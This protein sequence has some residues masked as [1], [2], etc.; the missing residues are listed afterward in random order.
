MLKGGEIRLQELLVRLIANASLH[1]DGNSPLALAPNAQFDNLSQGNSYDIKAFLRYEFAPAT[2]IAV[3]IEKSWGGDQVASGGALRLYFGGPTS[4]GK[5]DFLKGH[6][7]FSFP[8]AA[9]F[10]VASD[11]T[12]D[13]EREGGFKEDFTAEVRLTKLFLPTAPLPM[14]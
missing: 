3:G 2:H 7:Q 10:H 13:F 1:T 9:D 4:L 6:L 8:L 11:L 14:K 12:H 5:D